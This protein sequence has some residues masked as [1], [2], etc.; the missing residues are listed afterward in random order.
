MPDSP[1][2]LIQ[3]APQFPIIERHGDRASLLRL[4]RSEQNL[5]ELRKDTGLTRSLL[6]ALAAIYR[7]ARDNS[8]FVVLLDFDVINHFVQTGTYGDSGAGLD[9]LALDVFFI[10]GTSKY[11]LPLGAYRELLGYLRFMNLTKKNLP[12][13]ASNQRNLDR[14]AVIRELLSYI[15]VEDI[16][17]DDDLEEVAEDLVY[18]TPT[19][20]VQLTRLLSIFLNPRF[21]GI[22]KKA[23]SQERDAWRLIQEAHPRKWGSPNKDQILEND[24]LN[25]AIS[26]SD[27]MAYAESGVRRDEGREGTLL[28]TRTGGIFNLLRNIQRNPVMQELCR[29]HFNHVPSA[30]LQDEFPV[31]APQRVALLEWFGS[32]KTR[33]DADRLYQLATRCSYSC[34]NVEKDADDLL[35][36]V[37]ERNFDKF[38]EAR[39]QHLVENFERLVAIAKEVRDFDERRRSFATV[40]DI[41]KRALAEPP[42]RFTVRRQTDEERVLNDLFLDVS[43][44]APQLLDQINL[45][46]QSASSPVYDYETKRLEDNKIQFVVYERG[47][48]RN[49]VLE[50]SFLLRPDGSGKIFEYQVCWLTTMSE[51]EFRSALEELFPNGLAGRKC[52]NASTLSIRPIAS[53]GTC[54]KCPVVCTTPLGVFGVCTPDVLQDFKW[55]D[56]GYLGRLCERDIKK[57]PKFE[58]I[59][60]NTDSFTL[61]YDL[62]PK[63]GLRYVTLTSDITLEKMIGTLVYY[64]TQYYTDRDALVSCLEKLFAILIK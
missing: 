9:S 25:L 57:V 51:I 16:A 26:L 63:G 12:D 59:Q 32:P 49:K 2:N 34:K 6:Q 47:S 54:L 46:L 39:S 56:L 22:R 17:P 21:D 42:G 31:I 15:S 62:W 41:A 35:D 61:S 58:Q 60:I 3:S 1:S 44:E 33:S 38:Y 4:L 29:K 11:A 37:R 5:L 28:L 53:G 50:G 48:I 64:S 52:P 45:A 27:F 10:D 30:A 14:N 13:G 23:N 43:T 40:R 36:G 24:A 18:S 55:L 20:R 8:S 7:R 19:S